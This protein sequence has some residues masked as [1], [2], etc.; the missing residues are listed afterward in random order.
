[1]PHRDWRLRIHDI[2]EAIEKILRY[3]EGMTFEE[4]ARDERTVDA[5]IRN[6]TVIGEASRHIPQEIEQRYAD[7]PWQE[8]RGMRHILVHEYFGVSMQ[9]L[10][11]TI[12]HDLPPLLPKLRSVLKE[13]P[14]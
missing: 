7:V 10:W 2:I 6:F 1:M 13:N 3:T 12:K 9:I 14:P 5:V 11:H 4:F 8:M